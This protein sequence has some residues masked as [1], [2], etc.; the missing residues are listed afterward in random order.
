MEKDKSKIQKILFILNPNA[1][2]SDN[3]ELEDKIKYHKD[4]SISESEIYKI[5]VKPDKIKIRKV[6]QDIKPSIVIAAGGDGTV[7]MIASIIYETD[8]LLGILPVGSAN[9]MAYELNISTDLS[10]ALDIIARCKTNSI[11]IIQINK[12]YISVHLSDLGMNARIVKR[13]K[14]AGERGLKGYFKQFIKEIKGPP[15]FTC[16]LS[17]NSRNVKLKA[18]MIVIANARH[19]GT[20]AR[21]NPTGN[22]SDG[23]FEVIAFKP[24]PYWYLFR[25]LIA[26][27]M[28]NL[29]KQRFVKT[30]RC[31]EVS[32][33][34]SP[35]QELQADGELL[36]NTSKVDAKIIPRSLK[37]I[38]P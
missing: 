11:D 10:E 7:N 9:G 26:F 33:S 34:V 13:F 29:H 38:V 6:I 24:L 2:V 36:E 17:H 25:L 28:G 5:S 4:K 22:I 32:L 14:Q 30:I 35:E 20:G 18:L 8:I 37:V 12:K 21:V 23:R 3:Q 27:F 1:G 31:K 19:Y 15:V 16:K